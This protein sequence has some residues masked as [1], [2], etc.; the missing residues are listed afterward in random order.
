MTPSQRTA[1]L[2]PCTAQQHYQDSR[3]HRIVGPFRV[4]TCIDA[5]LELD[6]LPVWH[7]ALVA[8]EVE[9]VPKKGHRGL[10]IRLNAQKIVDQ[11]GGE[12]AKQGILPKRTPA[13]WNHALRREG[14]R[15]IREV[16]RGAGWGE[17]TISVGAFHVPGVGT[18][19]PDEAA[20]MFARKFCTLPEI[21]AI[22]EALGLRRTI[23]PLWRR[24]WAA[25]GAFVPWRAD[26]EALHGWLTGYPFEFGWL[27]WIGSAP[28]DAQLRAELRGF[29]GKAA[30]QRL[31]QVLGDREPL[32]PQWVGKGVRT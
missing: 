6:K 21:L 28:G 20:D 32:P 19:N 24:V 2:I 23:N 17:P 31:R 27:A 5:S 4:A 13:N 22:S 30:L 3:F 26:L 14:E 16:L 12:A 25:A 11:T 18:Y 9:A 7:V 29:Q 1:V 15:V 8:N 10:R